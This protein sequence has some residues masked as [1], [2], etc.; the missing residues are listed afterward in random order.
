MLATYDEGKKYI[1]KP[2]MKRRKVIFGGDY[3]KTVIGGSQASQKLSSSINN[4]Q[5]LDD[6]K[7]NVLSISQLCDSG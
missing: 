1:S 3:H 5:L 4:L 2:K 7:H 6:P